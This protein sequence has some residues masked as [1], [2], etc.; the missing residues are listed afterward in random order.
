[1]GRFQRDGVNILSTSA[2]RGLRFPMVIIP[3]LD[4]GRFPARLRQDPLLLD[5][6]RRWME[7]LPIKSRRAEEESCSLIWLRVR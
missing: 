3:G 5:A 1:V 7:D 2:A 4:E 6:E